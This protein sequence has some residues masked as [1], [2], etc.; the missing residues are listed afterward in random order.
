MAGRL[1]KR[2]V[3]AILVVFCLAAY[4]PGVVRLPAVDRTE[5]I[6]AETTREMVAEGN[7]LDPRYGETVHPFRPIG[8]YW[9][10]G[11]AATL[12]GE[13]QARNITV[14]RLPGM[15]AVTLAVVA[16]FLL[17]QPLIGFQAALLAAG[18]FAVAPLTV[19]VAHLAIAEGL[20]L[21]PAVVAMLAL[22]RIYT[23]ERDEDTR[24]LAL[25]FWLA[26]GFAV[27]INAL[28]VPIIV[29]VTLI[30]LRFF[31]RDFWW[32]QRLH[33]ATFVWPALLIASPWLVVRFHQDG[34]PFSGLSFKAFIEALG[35]AQDMKLR[36]MPGTFILA[37]LLGFLPGTALVVPAMRRFWLSREGKLA[38]FLLAWV[39][40]YLVYLELFS[41]KPGTYMVQT[42]FPA[43]AIAV[44]ALAV[45]ADGQT[46]PPKFNLFLWP[47]LAA[48]FA[49][50]LFA[51]P[52][53]SLGVWPSP[54]LWLPMGLVAVLFFVSAA[55]G[56]AGDLSGWGVTGVAALALFAVTLIAGVFP[57]LERI[58]PAAQLSRAFESCKPGKRAIF[59]FNEPSAWFVA[60]GD[61]GLSTA[62]GLKQIA[63]G[64]VA[65]YAVIE[66][67]WYDSNSRI[68]S[69]AEKQQ[70]RPLACFNAV[71]VMRG[72]GVSLTITGRDGAVGCTPPPE[73]ACTVDFMMESLSNGGFKPCD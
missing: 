59:G 69:R 16:L 38:R 46:P 2:L 17:A 13:D 7:W 53:V 32:L 12:A 1:D 58:W 14:Y 20:S 6:F 3:S 67:N 31:D 68:L 71:N 26:L 52:H 51:L 44:G 50:L 55:R 19:L 60:G 72:C 22:L 62:D 61:R 15:L 65:G 45:S 47:P 23:A 54:W 73:F 8:T 10:Q 41:S 70:I 39:I 5:V 37:L 36:A 42:M 66:Q 40:G 57:S 34:V 64:S 30:A 4:L 35:G 9:A 27:L 49:A 56:R 25:F 21:L 11:L 29:V 48:L 43:L 28:L 63:N 18:L 24:R 33:T